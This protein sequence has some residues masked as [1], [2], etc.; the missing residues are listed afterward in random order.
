MRAPVEAR[1]VLHTPPRAS[2]A[3]TPLATSDVF[4]EFFSP[5]HSCSFSEMSPKLLQGR[6][7]PSWLYCQH[8]ASS[9]SLVK[10][11]FLMT[12]FEKTS[13]SSNMSWI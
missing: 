13:L 8:M 2:S 7:A 11:G 5:L 1:A 12:T 4:A 3:A 10:A 9:S 6:T